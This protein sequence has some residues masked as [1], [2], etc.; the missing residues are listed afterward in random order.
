MSTVYK[1]ELVSHWTDY[2]KEQLQKLLE[3]AIKKDKDFKK[4]KNEI[5]IEVIERA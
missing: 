2:T 1:I 5:T 4:Y 3:N